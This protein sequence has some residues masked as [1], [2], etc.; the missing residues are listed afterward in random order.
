MFGRG[1]PPRRPIG[2]G[3]QQALTNAFNL[4]QQGRFQEAGDIFEN[5]AANLEGRKMPRRAAH[6][7]IQAGHCRL[8]SGKNEAGLKLV[9]KGLQMLA[10]YQAWPGLLRAGQRVTDELQHLGMPAQAAEIQAW[11]SKT[12][13]PQVSQPAPAAVTAGLKK[14]PPKCPYCG[15]GL[16]SDTVDWIDPATAECPYCGSPVQSEG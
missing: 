3:A 4:K 2:A 13:P 8:K 14:L 10:D 16:R 6:L 1:M 9:H 15:A 7:Y 12:L 5:M 11:L